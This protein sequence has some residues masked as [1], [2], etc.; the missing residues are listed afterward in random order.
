M[1]VSWGRS[2]RNVTLE[3]AGRQM[4]RQLLLLRAYGVD[5]VF[6]YKMRQYPH[7]TNYTFGAFTPEYRPLPAALGLA[8]QVEVFPD[9]TKFTIV[10][11]GKPWIVKGVRPDGK[12]AWAIW[13]PRYDF[14]CALQI[15]GKIE[16]A[17]TN[18]GSRINIGANDFIA[19]PEL[20]F[21]VGPQ[22]IR[23]K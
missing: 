15:D 2:S 6:I 17:Y 10:R 1:N 9:G 13:N 11:Q 12:T 19:K 16:T 20:T 4:S 3:E 18:L 14:R 22:N 7:Q 21:I 5:K 23:V 8:T